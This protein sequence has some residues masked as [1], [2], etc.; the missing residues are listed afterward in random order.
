MTRIERLKEATLR[1]TTAVALDRARLVTESYRATESEPVIL[2]RAK[3]IAHFVLNAPLRIYDDEL[4][5][6]DRAWVQPYSFNYPD[7]WPKRVPTASDPAVAAQLKD[8]WGYWLD[9]KVVA[10]TCTT[11][12]GH[13][14][15]GFAKLLDV[16]F[17]G[18]ADEARG[19]LAA[20]EGCRTRIPSRTESR[21]GMD[22]S[23]T[24]VDRADFLR[25]EILLAEA[26]AALG[27]RF[28]VLAEAGA[29]G[30]TGARRAELLRIAGTCRRAPGLPP[31]D[32]REA[33]QCLWFGQ[34]LI[35]AEDAPNGQSPGRVDQVLY[36][37][38]RRDVDAGRLTR[39]EAKELLACLWLKL[40][41]P[42]DVHD[43]MVGGLRPDGSDATNEISHLILE[44]Q[45]EVG[46]HRQLSV[47]YHKDMPQDFLAKAC[48]VVRE[49][50]GV[51][52]FFNDDVLVPNLVESG[53]PIEDARDYA[54]IGCIEMTIPGRAD[55]RAVA[56]YS[57]LPECLEQTLADGFCP[58]AGKQVG[59]K[60]ADPCQAESFDEFFDL[61]A[62][63][64][65]LEVEAGVRTQTI[66]E[67][68]EAETYPMPLLSLLTEDCI[69]KGLDISAGGGR[70]FAS[71]YCAVGIPTVADSLMAIKRVVFDEKAVSMAALVE[72]LK[73][74]FE[75]HED[76]RLRLLNGVPKYGCDE[77]EVDLLARRVAAQYADELAKHRDSRGGK[78]CAAYFSFTACIGM[79]KMVGAT[80]DGRKAAQP[81]AN[82]LCATQGHVGNGPSELLKSAAKTNQRRALGGTSLL[83]DLH[84]SVVRCSG[85]T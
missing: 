5:V 50:L 42:Y 69:Q 80:P 71:M 70:R 41:A 33:V 55:A 62:R 26:C 63:R 82:S 24:I 11:L 51:P 39:D 46:L 64:V 1:R 75:G 35:E 2:R 49:G 9:P 65:A 66:N 84:P 31:R 8:I 28:A 19:S 13:C 22:S 30:A 73:A 21:P 6:G 27:T 68:R 16:G 3:A 32:F 83:L 67:Q 52:Q 76:F 25:A 45:S 34:L 18:L 60:L 15:P 7:M 54:I 29:A 37:F 40:Y 85:D 78:L 61:Y 56:H 10:P 72:M 23:P 17:L 12:K 43:T 58:V 20:I 44:V 48:D 4:I 74:N 14:V 57:N 47:R 79:G 38:Y 81:L 53:F 59:P 36:P 77:D